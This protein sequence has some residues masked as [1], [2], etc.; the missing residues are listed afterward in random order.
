MNLR[1]AAEMALK[2]LEN[3]SPDTDTLVEV[4]PHVWEYRGGLVIQAL[5]QALAQPDE[6]LAEPVAWAHI[7]NNEIIEFETDKEEC[8]EC[9]YC[10]PLYTAP[11]REWV[12]LTKEEFEQ[13]V[14]GLEDLED[15]WVQIEAKLREKNT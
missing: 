14:N 7:E 8:E 1:Q 10:V 11:Q 4:E 2:A 13:A 5:R 6:V 9:E 12:G 3:M 15:C